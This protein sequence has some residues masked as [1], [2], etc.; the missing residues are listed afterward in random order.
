[1][2]CAVEVAQDGST[3]RNVFHH[4]LYSGDFYSVANVVLVLGEDEETVDEV[5]DQ[6]L[7]TEAYRETSHTR[8]RQQRPHVDPEEREDL[9][10]CDRGDDEDTYAVGDAREGTKLPRANRG[11]VVAFCK[12][13]QVPRNQL[14]EARQDEGNDE[15]GDNLRD[16]VAEKIESIIAPIVE[17]FY[18]PLSSVGR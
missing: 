3:Q 16:R 14:Q 13:G 18:H 11:W 7:S 2:N 9:H 8:A 5:F 17:D 12:A 10:G 15:D 4:S 6:R 1:M